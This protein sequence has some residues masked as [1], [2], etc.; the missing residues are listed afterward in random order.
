MSKARRKITRMVL[1]AVSALGLC[2][3]ILLLTDPPPEDLESSSAIFAMNST[4][5]TRGIASAHAADPKANTET[6]VNLSCSDTNQ[7]FETASTRLRLKG[8]NC[9]EDGNIPL[10]TQVRNKTNGYVATVF[11]RSPMDFTTDYINLREGQNEI[12]VKFQTEKGTI[13]KTVTVVRQPAS[14]SQN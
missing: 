1:L 7:T 14:T 9:T 6:L 13:E 2:S 8:A 11:H 4:S 3:T 5:L 10:N 12:D